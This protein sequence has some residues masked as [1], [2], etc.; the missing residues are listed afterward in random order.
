MQSRDAYQHLS[1]A[2]AWRGG[3]SATASRLGG[4]R[5]AVGSARALR[6][7]RD[8]PVSPKRREIEGRKLVMAGMRHNRRRRRRR[9]QAMRPVCRLEAPGR[10]LLA[11]A[12][13][14]I[15]FGRAG[16]IDIALDLMLPTSPRQIGRA[17]GL[18]ARHLT[19]TQTPPGPLRF[20]AG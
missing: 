19:S 18:S 7:D 3:A 5:H 10:R 16:D 8:G 12:D 17:G 4:S 11:A 1:I 2:S 20:D 15:Y 14:T 13:M 9:P 6:T